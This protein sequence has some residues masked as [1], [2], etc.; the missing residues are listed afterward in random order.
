LPASETPEIPHRPIHA[1]GNRQKEE[2]DL[3][4]GTAP[5]VSASRATDVRLLSSASGPT[6]SFFRLPSPDIRLP[7]SAPCPRTSDFCLPTSVFR[8]P[9][10]DFRLP[11]ALAP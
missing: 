11:S 4:T 10:S 5:S 9:S 1:A 7:S 8:L 3:P 2:T 6:T